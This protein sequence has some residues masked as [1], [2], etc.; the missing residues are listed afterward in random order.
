MTIA[1]RVK[2]VAGFVPS[3]EQLDAKWEKLIKMREDLIQM[4]SSGELRQYHDLKNLIDSS[5]FQQNRR[6]IETLKFKGSEEEKLILEYKALSKSYAIRNYEKVLHSD[7]LIRFK[8]IGTSVALKRFHELQQIVDSVEFR[9]RKSVQKKKEYIKSDDYELFKEFNQLRK[10]GDVSFWHKFGRSAEYQGYTKIIDSRELKR[11]E[12]LRIRTS[13]PKFLEH[14]DYLKDKKRFLKSEAYQSILT[15][16]EID[17]GQFMSGYRKLKKAKELDFFEKWE[18]IFEENFTDKKFNTDQ[19]QPENWWG[20]SLTG[21]SFSQEDEKQSFNGLK[22][23]DIQN[24]TLSVWAKKERTLGKIWRPAL[25]FLPHQF[26]YSSAILNNAASFRI[27]EGVVEAKVR[28]KIDPSITSAFSLTGEKPFPQIDLFR[29]HGIGLGIIEKKGE[30]ASK[31]VKVG[32]LNDQNYHIFRLELFNGRLVWKI[33]GI[34]VFRAS[35][36]I[37]E[38]LFFHILT[39]LHGEVNEHLL[40]HRFEIDWIRC[41]EKKSKV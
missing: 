25:G 30:R 2:S 13:E 5:A 19:W 40:P 37:R 12:E 36:E 24:N 31:Y 1:F 14:V 15:F 18:I 20:V 23:I 28:F 26:E 9:Q 27:K 41:L 38:P 34:E 6:E 10:S 39:T 7:R 22:N 21:S 32:G 11:L 33:N 8:K 4:E 29:R 16:K 35:T 17:M 3:A